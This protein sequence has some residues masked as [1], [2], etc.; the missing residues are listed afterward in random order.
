M[1]LA[2]Q[3]MVDILEKEGTNEFQRSPY[4]ETM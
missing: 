4:L 1:P 2:W 3:L